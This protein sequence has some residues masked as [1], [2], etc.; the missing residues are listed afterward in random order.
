MKNKKLFL[1][2]AALVLVAALMFGAYLATRPETSQGGKTITV[3]VV[4]KDGTEKD[5]TCKTDETFLGPVLVTEGIVEDNQSDY[6]LYILT[7][8]GETAV[9]EEDGSWWALYVN[10]ESAMQ[11]ASDTPIHDG[12]AFRLVYTIG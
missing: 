6:G 10:G 2:I 9:W 7:A 11:G 5:F 8:D 3:T 12:D 4:H 1:A